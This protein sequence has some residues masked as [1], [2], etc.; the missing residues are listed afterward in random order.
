MSNTKIK[1]NY[2]RQDTT[3]KIIKRKSQKRV[4]VKY[5]DLL[6]QLIYTNSPNNDDDDTDEKY[7]LL[8]LNVDDEVNLDF[9]STSEEESDKGSRYF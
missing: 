4:S 5:G 7:T 2:L 3:R 1:N 9:V 6:E 8:D